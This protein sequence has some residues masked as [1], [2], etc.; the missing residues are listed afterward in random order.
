MHVNKKEFPLFYF[1]LFG[2]DPPHRRQLGETELPE[3]KFLEV[4]QRGLEKQW[5][6]RYHSP[7][8]EEPGCWCNGRNVF[9]ITIIIIILIIIIFIISIIGLF[10]ARNFS[11]TNLKQDEESEGECDADG[12]G[13]DDVVDDEHLVVGMVEHTKTTTDTWLA[14]TL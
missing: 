10:L 14:F 13:K 5:H 7:E 1:S 4:N 11:T 8:P 9:T 6:D 12:H 3:E 2:F